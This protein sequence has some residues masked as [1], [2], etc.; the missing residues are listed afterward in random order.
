M[1]DLIYDKYYPLQP[2]TKKPKVARVSREYSIPYDVAE[3]LGDFGATL[4]P[5][6]IM[7]DVDDRELANKILKIIDNEKIQCVVVETRRGL[8]FHFKAVPTITTNKNNYVT[9]AGLRTETKVA[10]QSV[11]VPV[12]SAGV[13]RKIIRVCKKLDKLPLWLYPISKTEYCDFSDLG[14]AEGRND[15]LFKYILILQG[16]SFNKEQIREIIRIIN[17][18]VLKDPISD[19]E[20]ETILRDE[21]FKKESFYIKGKLQYE[22]LARFLIAEENII[23]INNQLHIYDEGVYTSDLSRIEKKLLN[24]INNSIKANRNEVINY[25]EI[26]AESKDVMS[27]TYVAVNNGILN[28]STLTLMEFSP[29]HVIKNKINVNYNPKAYSEV[30]DKTLDKICCNNK[31]LRNLME[32]MVGYTLFKRNELR[33]CFILTGDGK[34]GKSTLL[35]IIKEMLGYHNISSV[36]LDELGDRFKTYQLEGKLANIGDDISNKYIEDNSVFKKLVTGE[37]VNVEKKG[38]DPYDFNNYSKLIF[39]CNEIPRINDYSE[40]L[41]SRIL[42]VPFNAVF[43]KEDPDFD[44]FIKDKLTT[45]ESL[46]YLLLLGVN[47]LLRVLS[48]HAFTQVDVVDDVWNEYEKINNPVVAF[49]DDVKVDKEPVG[50][51]FT[52]YNLWCV[53]NGY[54]PLSKN[55]LSRELKKQG[56]ESKV[57]YFNKVAKRYWSK[58]VKK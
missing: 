10:H 33:K 31:S 5:D 9:T 35:D 39:S 49:I 52:K 2:G 19:K 44:P 47:A 56:F 16:Q 41:K 43:S 57:A 38:K 17:K 22:K 29:N 6:T 13:H 58:E 1:Y 7:V 42:F 15:T 26:L 51:V 30:M 37:T 46:E 55:K 23:K 25:L 18:Y 12:K 14:Y 50:Q 32:E 48:D 54:K 11:V 28:L 21:S 45:K 36:S 20:L 8:H 24:Y 40:G 53:E 34:N 4:K 27:P 3:E